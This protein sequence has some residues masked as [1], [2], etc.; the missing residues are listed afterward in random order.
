MARIS[1]Q[2]SL[3]TTKSAQESMDAASEAMTGLKM[4]PRDVDGTGLVGKRG[5][6]IGMAMLGLL[7]SVE[8][9]PVK[10]EVQVQDGGAQRTVSITSTENYLYPAYLW[11]KG[12]MQKA[13]DLA[14]TQVR[15]A[16][17]QQLA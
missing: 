12:R 10:V 1:R 8:M 6:F 9:M 11:F 7:T 17:Q 14:F 2:E 16:V 3:T 4:K 15:D 5:S 13:V